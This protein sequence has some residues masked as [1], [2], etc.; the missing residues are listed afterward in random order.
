MTTQTHKTNPTVEQI[1]KKTPSIWINNRQ[2]KWTEKLW[3]CICLQPEASSR[4]AEDGLQVRGNVHRGIRM[5]AAILQHLLQKPQRYIFA[6]ITPQGTNKFTLLFPILPYNSGF[7]P[8]IYLYTKI[9]PIISPPERSPPLP[10]VSHWQLFAIK[11]QSFTQQHLCF[12]QLIFITTCVFEEYK[13]LSV[14]WIL[15]SSS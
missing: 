14:Y 12:A 1:R 7:E 15:V 10:C 2:L 11:W 8:P 13:N 6:W 3:K 9:I 4:E 5:M